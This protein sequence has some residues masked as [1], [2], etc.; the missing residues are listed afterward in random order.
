MMLVATACKLKLKEYPTCIR[1]CDDTLEVDPQNVKAMY[2]RAQAL[3]TPAS[4]GA[5]EFE[6]ALMNLQKAYELDPSNRDVRKMYRELREQKVKQREL[7]KATFTGMFDR[8][9]VCDESETRKEEEVTAIDTEEAR[10]KKFEAEVL[11]SVCG[12]VM[13]SQWLTLAHR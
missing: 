2:R 1:A 13:K 4:S 8:G 9:I 12:L 7:D 11:Y 3:I 6:Q 10:E 5:L